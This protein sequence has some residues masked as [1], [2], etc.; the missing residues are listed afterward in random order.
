MITLLE[1]RFRKR[2]PYGVSIPRGFTLIELLVVIGLIAVL[3]AGIGLSMRDGNP[4]SALR[5]SQNSLAGLLASARGQA[6]LTQ[7][8]AMIVVD[9][10]EGKNECL[11]SLQVVVRTGSSA[12]PDKWR[13]VGDPVLLPQGIYV[14]PPPNSSINGVELSGSWASTRKSSG[15]SSASPG[16]IAERD[17]DATYTLAKTDAFKDRKYLRFQVFG[18]LGTISSSGTLLVTS[19]RR[20]AATSVVL[21]NPEFVRGIFVTKYGVATLINEGAT[22]DKL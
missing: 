11:R 6:A 5:A 8:D 13:P 3:A 1:G 7:A 20:T 14:V 2:C 16:A 18:P 19:G 10:T 22:F 17:P 4:S 21:D 15:F 9:A 12:A